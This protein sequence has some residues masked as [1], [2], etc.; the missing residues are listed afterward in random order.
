MGIGQVVL[1]SDY[2]FRMGDPD[3][4]ATVRAVAGLEG[5]D[6]ARV[7][8]GNLATLLAEVGR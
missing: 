1:G 6:L 3:P 7:L 8:A 4:V 5:D 2:P